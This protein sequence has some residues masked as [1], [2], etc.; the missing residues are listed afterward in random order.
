M[1]IRDSAAH[2]HFVKS[3]YPNRDTPDTRLI[4]DT[5]DDNRDT[6]EAEMLRA[7]LQ[8]ARVK[9]PVKPGKFTGTT[10]CLDNRCRVAVNERTNQLLAPP[11]HKLIKVEP[12]PHAAKTPQD[13]RIWPGIVLVGSCTDK[14]FIKNAVRYKVLTVFDSTA[15]FVQ[16]K[17]GDVTVGSEF[18][19]L[20]YTSPSPRDRQKSRMP[21]SA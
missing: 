6:D 10:L 9:Y 7:A 17:D 14:K 19:C 8:L 20:L 15:S 2:Y 16:V 4:R 5:P 21:S 12:N 3:I 11:G 1:C 18:T 13:M